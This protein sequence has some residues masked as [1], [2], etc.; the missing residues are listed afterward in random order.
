MFPNAE[1]EYNEHRKTF[2]SLGG[3][4]YDSAGKNVGIKDKRETR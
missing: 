4:G 2:L 3:E 1:T